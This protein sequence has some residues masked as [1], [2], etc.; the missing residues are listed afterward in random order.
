MHFASYRP[1]GNLDELLLGKADLTQQPHRI[2]SR[3]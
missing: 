3:L 2:Q 1:I